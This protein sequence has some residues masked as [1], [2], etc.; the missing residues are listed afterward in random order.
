MRRRTVLAGLPL[1]LAGWPRTV[2]AQGQAHV[3]ALWPFAEGDPEGRVLAES[4]HAG[5]RDHGHPDQRVDDRWTG[6]DRERTRLLATELV[7]A[8]PQVIFAYLSAQLTAVAALTKQI[9][10]VFVGASNP[11]RFGY[12]ESLQR[13]GGN[14]TGF[15]L[16]EAPLG[17][18]WVAALKEAVPSLRHVTLL[19]NPSTEIRGENLY[20]EPFRATAAALRIEPVVV[21]IDKAAEIEPVIAALARRGDGGLIVAPGT[22]SEA[23]G[24]HIVALTTSLRVPAVF[25]IRRFAYRG[26]LMSY[27]PDPV[28]TVRRAAAYVGRILRG[29]NPATLPVQAPTKFDF[30][31]NLKT[32]R[33]MGVTISSALLAQ[34]DEIVE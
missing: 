33:S 30:I 5:L 3:A 15:T 10:I 17:G 29:E 16:Y 25:A 11:V 34:A 19:S 18:K 31:V 7:A 27:G 8:Q 23:N 12:V 6:A 28:E 21:K 13:P 14:I 24:D 32:A 1:A 22:F 20:A 4:F 2:L 26:G 9:P